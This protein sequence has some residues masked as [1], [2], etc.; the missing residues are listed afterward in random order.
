MQLYSIFAPLSQVS[1]H[2][3]TFIEPEVPLLGTR[4]LLAVGR[5][6][7]SM[8]FCAENIELQARIDPDMRLGVRIEAEKLC[9]ATWMTWLGNSLQVAPLTTSL[10]LDREARWDFEWR[11]RE[12][13]AGSQAQHL[14]VCRSRA[15]Q[16]G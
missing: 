13:W 14:N 10:E 16:T 3:V 8:P 12:I 15:T 9:M 2:H 7:R 11:R 6:A 5:P 1:S 4:V